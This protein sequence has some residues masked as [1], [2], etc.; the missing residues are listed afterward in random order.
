MTWCS[1]C[2]VKD[3]CHLCIKRTPCDIDMNF[4]CFSCIPVVCKSLVSALIVVSIK[5]FTFS[6]LSPKANNATRLIA[7]GELGE[8]FV[9]IIFSKES[10][11]QITLNANRRKIL[12][13]IS[14]GFVIGCILIVIQIR[15]THQI[16]FEL[17]DN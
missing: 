3:S 13:V 5:N 8:G 14:G 9:Q 11:S 1:C 10:L 4:S 7:K 15:L 17:K 2:P 16:S 12:V 6:S